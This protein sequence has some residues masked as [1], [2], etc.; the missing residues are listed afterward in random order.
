LMGAVHVSAQEKSYITIRGSELNNGV[1]ILDVLKADKTYELQ[2]NHAV[3]RCTTLK[4][5]RY[6]M[7]ELPK[8]FGMYECK[9]VEIYP[10][11]AV[12]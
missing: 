12:K 2:C 11:S 10:E 9:N 8:D 3:P 6:Q 7:I 1:V 5:G 4:N